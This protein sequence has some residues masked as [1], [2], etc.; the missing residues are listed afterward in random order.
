MKLLRSGAAVLAILFATACA[1]EQL[2]D[3]TGP[4][5]E[6][7]LG[8]RPQLQTQLWC[9]ENPDLCHSGGSGDP[10]PTAPG[11]WFGTT[12]TP[13]TC[14]SASGAGI[15]DVDKDGM[16]D[17]CENVLA[18]SFAP[19]LISSPYDCSMGMEPYYAVKYFPGDPLNNMGGSGSRV[20]IFYAL[21][22]YLDCGD[23]S[24]TTLGC[25][26]A[27]IL[28][29]FGSFNGAL[30]SL[31]SGTW[32]ITAENHCAGHVGDSEFISVDVVYND[33][34][35]RWVFNSMFTSAH[36]TTLNDRSARTYYRTL[37]NEIQWE[38]QIGGAPRV[39]VALY[40]HA[41]YPSVARCQNGDL[42]DN[43]E[44]NAVETKVRTGSPYNLGSVQA[45]FIN[46]G[47]C[48]AGG[49]LVQ[50]Y[51]S[52]YRIECY[53]TSNRFAGWD[54]FG[55]GVTPYRTELMSQFECGETT[56]TYVIPVGATLP[57]WTF[58]CSNWGVRR[59]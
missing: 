53:W 10:N 9:E 47:S 1:N 51:P 30:N 44:G 56:L 36:Y 6:D 25:T 38:Q 40:K 48:V 49:A 16:N 52:D 31:S 21:S 37:R 43:C 34:T 14:F 54:K 50:Y 28:E 55:P 58:T 26:A 59:P 13:N 46:P 8:S 11:Y 20:R 4:T 15:N 5:P 24:G 35:Q 41:N 22:Y 17:Y 2:S 42:A 39:W 29:S 32:P 27:Q 18:S 33:A 7:G 3:P 23:P 45:N 12:V 57:Q 19:L